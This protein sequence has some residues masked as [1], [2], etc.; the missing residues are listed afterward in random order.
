MA[1]V[2]PGGTGIGVQDPPGKSLFAVFSL[3]NSA[4]DPL[5]EAIGPLGPITSLGRLVWPT[6]KFIDTVNVLKFQTSVACQKGP[7]K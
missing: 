6:L 2:D 1:W 7:V 4:T 5:R 3:R